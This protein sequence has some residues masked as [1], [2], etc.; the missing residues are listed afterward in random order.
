MESSLPT[1]MV[2]AAAEALATMHGDGHLFRGRYPT[3]ESTREMYR[4]QVRQILR[5]ALDTC[6]VEEDEGLRRFVIK[7][8]VEEASDE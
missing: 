7:T 3:R 6:D 8:P 1:A 4:D 5:A 2:E